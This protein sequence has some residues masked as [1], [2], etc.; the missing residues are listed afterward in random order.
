MAVELGKSKPR[1]IDF[2]LD[3][4]ALAA[5]RLPLRLALKIQSVGDGDALPADIVAEFIS[6][7]VVYKDGST[8]W[9]P[10]EV[11]DFDAENM[12]ELFQEVSGF[13]ATV[14]EAEKN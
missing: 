12:V 7:C 14:E 3:G 2:K 8:V 13:S 9:T 6:T 11:L 4:K 10:E 1:P 5:R